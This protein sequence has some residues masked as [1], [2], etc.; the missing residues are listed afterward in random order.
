M[1]QL[2]RKRSERSGRAFVLMLL[3]STKLLQSGNPH[4][5]NKVMSTLASSTRDTDTKGWYQERTTIG[6]IFTE[7]GPNADG[8][9]VS[10]A[11]LS[12][13]TKALSSSLSINEINEIRLCF[14]IFL[15]D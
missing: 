11:L 8:K 10:D 1:L 12:K 3:K 4:T 7:L 13:V 14:R 5:L 2:V 6:V 15:E 9:S